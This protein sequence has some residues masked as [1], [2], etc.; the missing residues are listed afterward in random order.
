MA[1]TVHIPKVNDDATNFPCW[2]PLV[3]GKGE[4]KKRLKPTIGCQ[5]GS[6]C[7]IGLHHVHADGRV[8]ASFYHSNKDFTHKGRQ[9]KGDPR[10]CGWHVY[11][12]LENYDWGEYPP[13]E[14]DA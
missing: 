3:T 4:D 12:V 14:E 6:F 10:G 11:L 5:C 1:E 9:Y 7:G 2:M 13:E 8:T